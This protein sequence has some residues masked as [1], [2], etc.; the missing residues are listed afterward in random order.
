[1]KKITSRSAF[2]K[3]LTAAASLAATAAFAQVGGITEGDSQPAPR[4]SSRS[5]GEAAPELDSRGGGENNAGIPG[6]ADSGDDLVG[7]ENDRDLRRR[8]FTGLVV[9]ATE[10]RITLNMQPPGAAAPMERVFMVPEGASVIVNGEQSPLS[11]IKKGQS[12]RIV[13]APADPELAMRV[14]VATP[15]GEDD[16][17]DRNFEVYPE[18]HQQTRPPR[19]DRR[20]GGAARGRMAMTGGEEAVLPLGIEVYGGGDRGALVTEML[21]DGPAAT[22]GVLINDVIVAVNGRSIPDPELI[23]EMLAAG[24]ARGSVLTVVRGQERLEIPVTA[25]RLAEGSLVTPAA[26]RQSLVGAGFIAA[27]VGGGGVATGL[28]PGEAASGVTQ[29]PPA[30]LNKGEPGL[31][32]RSPGRSDAAQGGVGEGRS[33][34]A[35]GNNPNNRNEGDGT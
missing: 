18:D 13:T 25:G 19:P 10:D 29:P 23:E 5:T 24:D 22:A 21:V 26:M 20:V 16:E 35:P 14:F 11:A 4:R 9:G 2:T 28:G 32:P 15:A 7:D 17:E 31:T 12:A 1:M 33:E 6:R 34:A 3:L 30:D 8:T 27:P